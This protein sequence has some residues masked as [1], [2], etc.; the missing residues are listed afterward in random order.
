MYALFYTILYKGFEHCGFWNQ[1]PM[2]A[3]GQL[4]LSLE[5]PKV[6]CRFSTVWWSAP[7]APALL[8]GQLYIQKQLA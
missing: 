3:E 5:G 1:R 8:K 2:D 6:I 7:L 4:L